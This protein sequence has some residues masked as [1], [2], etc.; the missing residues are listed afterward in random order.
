MEWGNPFPRQIDYR[1]LVVELP[2]TVLEQEGQ[3]VEALW[4]IPVARIERIRAYMARV[5]N[6]LVLW[7]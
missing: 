6:R 1:R 4:S 5:R 7:C 2:H 3:L